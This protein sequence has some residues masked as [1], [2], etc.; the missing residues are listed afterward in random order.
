MPQRKPVVLLLLIRIRSG[1]FLI[2]VWITRCPSQNIGRGLPL[3]LSK[4][5]R[6]ICLN[7]KPGVPFGTFTA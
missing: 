5:A 6:L 3:K 2:L 4:N 1:L 7:Q